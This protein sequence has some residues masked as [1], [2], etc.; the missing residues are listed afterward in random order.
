MPASRADPFGANSTSMARRASQTSTTRSGQRR[1]SVPLASSTLYR[2]SPSASSRRHSRPVSTR[3]V[4][5]ASRSSRV[6]SQTIAAS[7]SRC[8]CARG[9]RRRGQPSSSCPRPVKNIARGCETTR[10][11]PLPR[12]PNRSPIACGVTNLNRP[13]HASTSRSRRASAPSHAH[14]PSNLGS[15]TS[16]RPHTPIMTATHACE[17][18]PSTTNVSA[19]CRSVPSLALLG[20]SGP[21]HPITQLNLF[22]V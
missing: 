4:S 7:C 20:R 3:T 18:H 9:A 21:D 13:I 10:V 15:T 17:V 16:S 22:T 6:T 14:R 5:V 12:M 19:G 2:S 1:R 8:T 11:R